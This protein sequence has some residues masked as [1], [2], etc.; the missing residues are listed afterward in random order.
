[1]ANYI[2][3]TCGTQ[4]LATDKPPATCLICE[5]ERQYIGF[6]G[7]QWTTLSDM[8]A[9]CYQT[10][11]CY[12]EP[13]VYALGTS[14]SFAIGQR[15][16]FV[17]TAHGNLLWDC[18][19]FIDHDTVNELTL[20]GGIQAIAVSHPHFYS[21]MVEWSHA[22]GGAPIYLPEADKQWIMRPDPVI[23]FWSG[24]KEL[25]PGA[26]V[27]QCGGHF[28]G[29]SVLH[30]ADGAEGRGVLFVADT[31]KVA[32][33]RKHVSFMWSYPNLVPL[34][35]RAVEQIVSAVRPYKFDRIYGG[36]RNHDIL[37]GAKAAVEASAERYVK[38]IRG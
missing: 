17:Q 11:L 4:Y 22:F 29:S 9:A 20:R 30:W 26:T 28:P 10:A 3:Q 1:M 16:F 19:S 32:L 5:D 27:I 25:V 21:S 38:Q 8:K 23:K 13:S 36:W 7:Q 37:H 34:S 33:D 15:A 18:V 2:C 35:A 31:M 12:L 6:E 24:K 14:P